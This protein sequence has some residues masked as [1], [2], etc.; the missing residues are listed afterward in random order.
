MAHEA[1]GASGSARPGESDLERLDRNLEELFGGLRVALPG[2]QVLFAFLLVLPFQ[3]RFGG[4]NDFEKG[5]FYATLVFTALASVF[6]IAAPVR[7]RIRFRKLDKE[8][9]VMSANRLAIVGF[10]CLALALTGAMV[11]VSNFLFGPAAAIP[12]G[13]VIGAAL[14]WVWFGSPLERAR[15]R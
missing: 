15:S 9:I 10:A 1:T 2:V 12:A 7:H 14:A 4:V 11:L 8:Y 13:I 6:L 5:V 3:S